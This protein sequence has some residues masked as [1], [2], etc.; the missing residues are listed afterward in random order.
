MLSILR[1]QGEP[2]S[3]EGAIKSSLTWLNTKE[4]AAYL[5]VSTG[6]ILNLVSQGKLRPHK[7]GKKNRYRLIDIEALIMPPINEWPP[8][9]GE[10]ERYPRKS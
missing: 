8:K 9:V 1:N 7:L 2:M 4:A 3:N 10:N 5:K 6:H